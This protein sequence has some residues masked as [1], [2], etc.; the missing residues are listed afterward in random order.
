MIWVAISEKDIQMANMHEKMLNTREMQIKIMR[1]HF[2]LS[3]MAITT[4]SDNS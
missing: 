2:L 4:E 3:R 1:Y